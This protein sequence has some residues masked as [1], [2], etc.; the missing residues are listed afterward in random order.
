[1][2]QLKTESSLKEKSAWLEAFRKWREDSAEMEMPY[3]NTAVLINKYVQN[4]DIETLDRELGDV[5]SKVFEDLNIHDKRTLGAVLYCIFSI[6]DYVDTL[7]KSKEK[8]LFIESQDTLKRIFNA[9]LNKIDDN[10]SHLIANAEALMNLSF[11]TANDKI[12]VQHVMHALFATLTLVKTY[13]KTY[14]SLF[15]MALGVKQHV[16]ALDRLLELAKI[17]IALIENESIQYNQTESIVRPQTNQERFNN[18][19]LFSNQV[20]LEEQ[21]RISM[22]SDNTEV[23]QLNR[24]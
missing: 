8:E 22:D 11:S 4:K 23:L 13:V 18:A 10:V 12:A 21:N 14:N 20:Y 16:Q 6:D 17:K 2:T 3:F 5:N 1:M 19:F 15:L 7:K 9:P 24:P